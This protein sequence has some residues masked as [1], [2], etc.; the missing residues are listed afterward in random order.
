MY[1]LDGSR[2]VG[3]NGAFNLW[4]RRIRDGMENAS[5]QEKA[6]LMLVTYV[7]ILYLDQVRSG[8]ATARYKN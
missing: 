4:R 1:I 8:R 6:S 5:D 7:C 3:S 2:W